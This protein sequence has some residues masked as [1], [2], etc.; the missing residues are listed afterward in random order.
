MSSVEALLV[1]QG[2]ANGGYREG[3]KPVIVYSVDVEFH[4]VKCLWGSRVA[5]LLMLLYTIRKAVFWS[6]Q[7]FSFGAWGLNMLFS[8][9]FVMSA[10]SC[11]VC[12]R[13][14]ARC[15]R[16]S[17]MQIFLFGDYGCVDITYAFSISPA[18]LLEKKQRAV[19]K[20]INESC[21]L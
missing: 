16:S 9:R 1:G 17:Q 10:A 2:R 20:S 21:W 3:V 11:V 12:Y 15:F 7:D 19:D 13:L 8:W 6:H 14:H 4:S 5:Y 18:A